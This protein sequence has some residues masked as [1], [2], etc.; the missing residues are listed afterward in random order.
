MLSPKSDS[1]NL[2]DQMEM[3]NSNEGQMN[4][5]GE[6]KMN[7]PNG[8]SDHDHKMDNPE[9]AGFGTVTDDMLTYYTCPMESHAYVKMPNEGSCP[10]CGMNLIAKTVPYSLGTDYYTC[11]MASHA[12]VVTESEGNCPLCGMALVKVGA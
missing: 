7:T 5:Q 6:M 1:G 12:H 11:P 9:A 2:P 8:S 3:E 4:G 10:D